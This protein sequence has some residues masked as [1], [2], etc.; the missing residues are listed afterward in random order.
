[1]INDDFDMDLSVGDMPTMGASEI[2]INAAKELKQALL[3]PEPTAQSS[4]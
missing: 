3:H 4:K 2:E 1:M